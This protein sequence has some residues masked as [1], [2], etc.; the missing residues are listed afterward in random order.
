MALPDPITVAANSPTP[1]LVFAKTR[2]DGYGSEYVDSGGNGYLI[3][4]SHQPGKA[5]NRHYVR[6]VRK[7]NAVNPFSGLTQAKEASVSLSFVQ[8]DFGFTSADMVALVQ[9]MF[10]FIL[11][12]EVTTSKLLLNQS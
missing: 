4:I 11:D 3:T 9:A 7:V 8:P 5:S 6:L 12:S 10:D 2:F 1:Q